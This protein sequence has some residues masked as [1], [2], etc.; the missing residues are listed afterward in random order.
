MS[1]I[2][3]RLRNWAYWSRIDCLPDL[4]YGQPPAFDLWRAPAD[5]Y[6]LTEAR[7]EQP[8]DADA[9]VI[10]HLLTILALAHRTVIKRHYLYDQRQEWA[11]LDAACRALDD[12]VECVYG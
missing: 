1:Q 7:P 3:S 8:D 2:K 4:S 12:I 5:P 9:L 10:D 6:A 11:V